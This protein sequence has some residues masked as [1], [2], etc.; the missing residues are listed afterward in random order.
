MNPIVQ[1]MKFILFLSV[2]SMTQTTFAK[3]C[4]PTALSAVKSI[5][6]LNGNK[7]NAVS[8]KLYHSGGGLS[9]IYVVDTT[10]EESKAQW[11]VLADSDD[12]S[13]SEV[14][15]LGVSQW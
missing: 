6:T 1:A 12:C 13:I 7:E 3:D 4:K 14:S 11:K 5:L 15:S 8:A 9:D 2:L 10:I